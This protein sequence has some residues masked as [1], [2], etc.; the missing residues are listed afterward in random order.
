[1]TTIK[2]YTFR[3]NNLSLTHDI[4]A[5]SLSQALEKLSFLYDLKDFYLLGSTT[6]INKG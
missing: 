4:Y 6:K 1:M 5:I 2:K 3:S